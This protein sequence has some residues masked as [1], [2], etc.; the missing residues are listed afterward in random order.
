M[1]LELKILK[2]YMEKRQF[3]QP[4]ELANLGLHVQNETRFLS[5]AH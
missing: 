2:E 5:L 3:L 4:T 1:E